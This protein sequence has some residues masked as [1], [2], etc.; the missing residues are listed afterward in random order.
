MSIPSIVTTG[1][2]A[3]RSTCV[4][5]IAALAHPDRPGGAHVVGVVHLEHARPD[6]AGVD[7]REDGAEGEPRQEQVV[8]PLHRAAAVGRRREDGAI[9]ADGRPRRAGSRRRSRGSSRSRAGAPPRRP[10]RRSSRR[11]RAASAAGARRGSRSGARSSSQTTAPPT[12]SDIVTGAARPITSSTGCRFRCES[13]RSPCTTFE[14]KEPYSRT[15]RA[16][17]DPDRVAQRRPLV[18]AEAAPDR[19]RCCPG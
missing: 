5:R 2:S 15:M 3:F 4:R 14:T 6:H 13:P 1:S 7:R 16:A 8:G 12:T 19:L 9:A 10:A 18:D 11:G 17:V